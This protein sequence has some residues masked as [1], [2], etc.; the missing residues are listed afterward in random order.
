[1]LPATHDLLQQFKAM[2]DP[3]RIRLLALC[4]Q[5]ECSVSELTGVLGLSQPRASQHL[6]QLCAAGLLERFRDGQRVY[7]RTPTRGSGAAARRQLL[8]L[9]PVR[10][11]LFA[12]DTE[13]LRRQ[14]SNGLDDSAE[15]AYPVVDRA[16]HRALLDLTVTA[17]VGDLLDIGCGRG[18]VLKLLASRANR[19]VGVDIDANARH[20]ARAEL[21]L[22][23]LRNCSLRAGDMY[24]LPFGAAEFDTVILDDTL[25]AAEEPVAA[26]REARRML[27][28]GGRLVILASTANASAANVKRGLAGWCAEAELRLAPARLV[29]QSDPLWLLAVALP[30]QSSSAAA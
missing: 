7:Y 8:A 21:L 27:R 30:A 24:R 28:E 1:M 23:G 25:S 5:G 9:I 22:A 6:K 4:R 10:D 16:V 13:C 2:A 26:L 18:R 19:A 3:L 20:L 12:A 15:L 29:P 11:P 14:R 17:P